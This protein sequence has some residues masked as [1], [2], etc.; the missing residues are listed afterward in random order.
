MPAVLVVLA[1]SVFPLL[2]SLY[3]S[4]SRFRFVKGGFELKFI[5]LLNYKK[6]LLGS[7]QFHFLGDVRR[8]VGGE[9]GR[10][11]DRRGSGSSRC[12]SATPGAKRST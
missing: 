1:M 5:G 3:L 8:A 9:L 11:R 10:A 12:W 2:V 6:L 7:E 4:L